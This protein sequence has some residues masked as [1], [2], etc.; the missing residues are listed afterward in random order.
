[1]VS[2]GTIPSKINLNIGSGIIGATGGGKTMGLGRLTGGDS[3]ASMEI[4]RVGRST[5][6]PIQ[7]NINFIVRP[8]P[9]IA[10]FILRLNFEILGLLRS[11][12]NT[13]RARTSNLYSNQCSL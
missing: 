12:K 10:K 7:V 3:R 1:M 11:P 2:K 5:M 9:F 6:R 13:L 8:F 4:A